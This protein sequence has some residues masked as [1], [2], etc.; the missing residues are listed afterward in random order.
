MLNAQASTAFTASKIGSVTG[1]VQA[2]AGVAD[3]LASATTGAYTFTPTTT[4][5]YYAGISANTQ[6]PREYC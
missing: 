4:G 6:L 3:L 2:G 1:I 5:V